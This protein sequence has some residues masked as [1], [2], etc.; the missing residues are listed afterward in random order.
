MSDFVE[1]PPVQTGVARVFRESATLRLLGV[2]LLVLLLQVPI[3]MIGG[4]VSE[5]QAR[6]AAAIADVSSKWGT[7]QT[8]IGPAL[9]LPYT[10]RVV[11]TAASGLQIPRTEMRTAIVLPSTLHVRGT[12]DAENRTRGIFSIPV[13]RLKATIEGEFARIAPSDLGVA[14]SDV[15]WDRA[16]L[17]VGVTDVRAIQ[18]QT[19][20]TWNGRSVRFDPGVGRFV[21]AQTG[22]HADVPVDD[23]TG[24]FAFSFPLS[25]NG[26]VSLEMV[27]FAEETTVEIASNSPHPNFH[28]AWLPAQRTVSAGG[29]TAK[30]TIPF[31]GRNY[32]QA[33]TTV[34][35]RDTILKSAFGVELT[36]PVDYY[37]MADRS[38]KYAALF[39]LLTFASV[40]LIEVLSDVRIH[41]IQYLLLGA[42][43]CVFYL[44]ELSL[45]EHL[46]FALAYA[47]A[48]TSVLGLV[49]AYSV[50]ILRTA[51]RAAMV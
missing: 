7:S 49:S 16:H 26:S 9:A 24:R 41:P 36:D 35:M 11:E 23:A 27:P 43:L 20:L 8:V 42:A 37:R 1:P 13:Y 38:V 18:E 39:I 33:W 40:W 34:N 3:F 2:G 44:L 30:W 29:F 10:A 5:R 15:A 4:L 50:A 17:V 45:A 19:V 46:G 6:R 28:G 32:P 51:P 47:I 14:A 22:L 25:L 48:A 31:L 12:L 21:D